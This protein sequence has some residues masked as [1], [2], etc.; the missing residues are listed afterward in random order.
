MSQSK[1]LAAGVCAVGG[2]L[3][4]VLAL[5]AS[6]YSHRGL[7]AYFA[8]VFA[9]AGLFYFE[10]R[11]RERTRT[12]KSEFEEP[13]YEAAG[14]DSLDEWVSEEGIHRISSEQLDLF[15]GCAIDPVTY[16]LRISELVSPSHSSIIVES[17][18]S[19]RVEQY[20]QTLIGAEVPKLTPTT[21]S[22][23][24]PDGAT[25][26][27][28]EPTSPA[29]AGDLVIP[30]QFP[31][32]GLLLNGFRA[33]GPGDKRLSTLA[34]DDVMVFEMAVLRA[35]A[36]NFSKSFFTEYTT[37]IEPRVADL[38]SAPEGR[39]AG[40]VA[41]L[42]QHIAARSRDHAPKVEAADEHVRTLIDVLERVALSHPVCVPFPV[43]EAKKLRWP[44]A[45]RFKLEQ[46]VVRPIDADVRNEKSERKAKILNFISR[47][48]EHI[49]LTF[50]V[51]P[52]RIYF[53]IGNSRLTRSYHLQIEGAPG[54]FLASPGIYGKREEIAKMK[55]E[56]SPVS[57]QRRMH[58][59]F[60]APVPEK[61][62]PLAAITDYER[63]SPPPRIVLAANFEERS[64]GSLAAP[65]FA[66][67]AAFIVIAA[68]TLRHVLTLD[69]SSLGDTGDLPLI[70][71]LLAVPV[72]VAAMT[73][74]EAGR[75]NRRPSMTAR[76]V[77]LATVTLALFGVFLVIDQARS[78]KLDGFDPDQSWLAMSAAAAVN[79]AVAAGSWLGRVRHEHHLTMRSG[80]RD[81][82]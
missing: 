67:F 77:P 81:L 36:F 32:R 18:F 51:R 43:E 2:V 46:R 26:A 14:G 62:A 28:A 42:L 45:V 72:A 6:N 8:V 37:S 57:G 31:P 60:R 64:P 34:Y 20:D 22:E 23:V 30:L 38:L 7:S 80:K 78:V 79:F 19:V 16:F 41:P 55:G 59:Y 10:F 75:E 65:T 35:L 29:P 25:S 39:K 44:D 9:V 50:G 70:G 11:F 3:F 12:Q 1:W 76:L 4:I 27:E 53:E 13:G 24:S 15:I 47:R 21:A 63:P 17:T 5:G 68:I 48:L 82:A 49:R 56:I 52:G 61:K 58:A 66:A 69:D 40:E 71:L 54:T 74:F 33:F 73:G